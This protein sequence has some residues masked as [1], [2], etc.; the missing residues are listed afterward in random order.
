[1]YHWYFFLPPIKPLL[2]QDFSWPM[3]NLAFILTRFLLIQGFEQLQSRVISTC[4]IYIPSWFIIIHLLKKLSL[5]ILRLSTFWFFVLFF[6]FIYFVTVLESQEF[7]RLWYSW[8]SSTRNIIWGKR[9]YTFHSLFFYLCWTAK[10]GKLNRM[11][12]SGQQMCPR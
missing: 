2:S 1:M 10:G 4:P 8:I 6:S 3:Q 12:L 7:C 11:L 9:I 5:L